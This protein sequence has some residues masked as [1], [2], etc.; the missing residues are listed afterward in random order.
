MRPLRDDQL[1][2]LA[3]RHNVEQRDAQEAGVP[4]AQLRG[5]ADEQDGDGGHH[6][7]QHQCQPPLDAP[8]EVVRLLRGVERLDAALHVVLRPAVGADAGKALDALDKQ[9]EQR[10]LGLNVEQSQLARCAEV[11]QLDQVQHSEADGDGNRHVAGADKDEDSREQ[12]RQDGNDGFIERAGKLAVD[13]PQVLTEAVENRAGILGRDESCS[14]MH[15]CRENT[16]V[17]FN[18]QLGNNLQLED[19]IGQDASQKR[20]GRNGSVG[21]EPVSDIFVWMLLVGICPP[22]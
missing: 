11:V 9:R 6:Q 7:V 15:R 17:E 13:Q 8:H 12:G 3:K 2:R 22:L 10:R 14:C 16:V 21:T 18:H 1:Q 5:Q 19:A 20:R 4:A